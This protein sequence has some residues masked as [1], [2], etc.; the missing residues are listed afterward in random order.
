MKD[1]KECKNNILFLFFKGGFIYD[2]GCLS[3]VN[4]GVGCY[5]SLISLYI[6][7]RVGWKCL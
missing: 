5:G 1:F 3:L 4:G 7:V 2:K 6:F